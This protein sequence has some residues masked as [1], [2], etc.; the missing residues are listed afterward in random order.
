MIVKER[1]IPLKI[2]VGEALLRRLPRDFIYR[3]ELQEDLDKRWAGYW[4]EQS[5]DHHLSFLDEKKYLI[6]HD[7][8]L[9]RGEYTFQID[10]LLLS[11]NLGIIIEVKNIAGTL[12]FDQLFHQLIRTTLNGKEEGFPD[13]ITQARLHQYQLKRFF[14]N[15]RLPEIPIEYVVV[16]CNKNSILKT[17]PGYR[18]IFEKVFKA[19]HLLSRIHHLETMYQKEVL[20]SKDLLKVS[21]ML[22]VVNVFEIDSMKFKGK[23]IPE[24]GTGIVPGKEKLTSIAA[25]TGALAAI[26]GG[27]FVMGPNDGTE[28]DLAGVSMV[29]GK[30]ISE[31]V[32][33]RTSLVLS[34]KSARIASVETQLTVTASDGTKREVDGLNRKPGLIR[35]CGGIGDNFDFPKHD[36]T[37]TDPGELIQFTSDFG[38][39][40]EPGDG[41]EVVLNSRGQVTEVRERRGWPIPDDSTVLAGTGDASDWLLAHAKPGEKLKIDTTILADKQPLKAGPN[42]GIVNGG[43]RLLRAG[44]EASTAMSEGFHWNDNPEFYYRFGERRNPRTLAGVTGDGKILLVTV[45]GRQPFYSVG[46]SFKES[47]SIMKALGAVDAVNLD[48]GGSTAMTMGAKLVNRPSDATGERPIGDAIIILP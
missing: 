2:Q 8:N 27:Y 39:A 46:A 47:A 3:Q 5:L 6:F 23:V 37:C 42:I 19:P 30:L 21:R 45:D 41:V 32:N 15:H 22:W 25:R 10:T 28:G 38:S 44:K 7:L 4:G 24:L 40:T 1:T 35:G 43:P 34:G 20:S 26:N 17:N 48:G 14:E 29:G 18:S 11:S 33:G 36:F 9:P 12:F 16:I 31:A 13:P